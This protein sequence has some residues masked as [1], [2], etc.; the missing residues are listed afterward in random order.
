MGTKNDIMGCM[1]RCDIIIPVYNAFDCLTECIDSVLNG[2]DFKNSHLILID[3]KSTDARVLPLLEDY[4]KK[5]K[6]KITV[7]KNQK[8]LG[9]VGTVNRGM[10]YSKNDVLLLNSDTEVPKGWMKRIMECAY[11]DEAIAT[12]T[13]LSN[14][15][16]LASVP[17]IFERNELPIGYDL[18]KMDELVRQYSMKDYPEIPT[19]HGFCMYIKREALEK[20]GFFDEEH[21]GKGYG[22]END[23]S[24]RCFEKGY[25][26]VLCDNVYVLHK[27]SQSFL[28]N[29]I[30]NG[31]ALAKK[32]P[33]L[34]DNLDYWC[35]MRDIKK[36]GD[37]V[38]LAMGVQDVRP[39]ILLIVH[40][41]CNY[42]DNV[43]GTT[44][45]IMDVIKN[46]RM[47]YN[48]HVL[49]PEGN[50]YKLYSFFE[51]S[52]IESAVFE[53]P[54]MIE[55]LGLRSTE[56]GKMLNSIIDDYK[57]SFVHI[58]HMIGH[59]F[60][61]VDVCKK[62]KVEYA[63][64]LHDMYLKTPIV[65]MLDEKINSTTKY[66]V[67]LDVWRDECKRLFDGAIK[68]IAPSK[69]AKEAY[70]DVYKGCN[71]QVIKHGVDIISEK[72]DNKGAKKDIAFVG[73]IFPHKGSMI[74]EKL[75]K[76]IKK[77][78]SMKIHLFGMT[79]ANVPKSKYFINHGTYKRSD[80]AKLLNDN[81]ISLVCVFSLAPETFAYTVEEVVAAGVPVLT[82]DIGAAAER[83]KE[84]GLGWV[85]DYTDDE[86]TI[87]EKIKAILD[88]SKQY[89]AIKKNIDKY[90]VD[91]TRDMSL[92]Y[93]I[94]YKKYASSRELNFRCLQKSMLN[95]NLVRN[96]MLRYGGNNY[97][98]DYFAVI[99][100]RKWKMVSKIKI[101]KHAKEGAKKIYSLVKGKNGKRN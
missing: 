16:T 68:V 11:S 50:V 44:I 28:E 40:D 92:K 49:A 69:F 36:I 4:A 99:N 76:R 82:F 35:K 64:S 12:V 56:Y 95:A 86:K 89:K 91:S 78:D 87:Y 84:S 77:N 45:H 59:D 75:V 42:R 101:P 29:K 70:E 63:V 58:H 24:F 46:L 81:Q 25:R 74:L 3:D 88:D 47:K 65:S 48:F 17:R 13:P 22:E 9:F 41:F 85:I 43:G 2:T 72:N 67:D 98:N 26:S 97:T 90:K 52:E 83:V 80:L 21:F 34:K 39:N 32:H 71:I 7:L 8:N 27:E 55:P 6:D 33:E 62:K 61:I 51:N 94:I 53:R 1:L 19:A 14:N 54:I 96:V 38:A 60:N 66:P 93:E 37:N 31:A 73:A 100:S 30:D 79:T 10:K 5:Y 57:I 23:F 15:A 20:V 18:E